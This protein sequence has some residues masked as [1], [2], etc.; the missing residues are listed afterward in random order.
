MNVPFDC[1]PQVE[2]IMPLARAFHSFS[3]D[4]IRRIRPDVI[5]AY[6]AKTPFC[7]GDAETCSPRGEVEISPNRGER[8]PT[9]SS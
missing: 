5:E 6:N 8:L 4:I 9:V 1:Q 7:V 3:E 2:G